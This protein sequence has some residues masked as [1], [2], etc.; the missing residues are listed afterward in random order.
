MT[1]MSYN[2]FQKPIDELETKDLA[3]LQEVTE[4]WY[5]EYKSILVQTK[6]IAKSIAA[7]ANH[8]GGW[9][10]YGVAE[11]TNK[12]TKDKGKIAGSFPGIPTSEIPRFTDNLRNAV[13]DC[14]NPQPYYEYKVLDG[15]CS[16]IG[17]PDGQSVLVVLIPPGLNCPYVHSDGRI[18]RRVGDASDPKYET[19][20]FILD[21]LW[22]KRRRAEEQF[23]TFINQEPELSKAEDNVSFMQIF[24]LPD[25]ANPIRSRTTLTFQEFADI[26]LDKD[27]IEGGMSTP[28]E[29]ISTM[30]DGFIARQVSDNNP[31]NFIPTWKHYNDG[32]S[33]IYFPLRKYPKDSRIMTNALDGYKYSQEFIQELRRQQ[34]NIGYI[35]DLHLM[36]LL[37][38]AYFTKHITLIERG[39]VGGAIFVKLAFRGVWRT[40]PFLD[41]QRF[42]AHINKYGLPVIQENVQISPPGT[43][44][45]SLLQ[46]N[47]NFEQLKQDF[48]KQQLELALFILFEVWNTFGIPI[49][50]FTDGE[51]YEAIHRAVPIFRRKMNK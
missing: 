24:L 44:F 1:K 38:T 37:I 42:I 48:E 2:P 47:Y 40:S 29:N 31:H 34:H 51:F 46:V 35:I 50:V 32:S 9:L 18:Y 26:L 22:E 30:T 21:Q 41:T 11:V 14:L 20:R 36:I 15:P 23:Q 12:S 28:F 43:G 8:Y 27:I 3:V 10:F 6:D 39:G 19:D 4:G 25:H 17:L 7:F 33:V 13:K 16:E 49:S 45:D 5:I